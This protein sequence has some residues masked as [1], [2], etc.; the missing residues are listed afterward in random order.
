MI[1]GIIKAD[2]T[3]RLMRANLPATYEEFKAQ[4]AAGTLPLDVLF[5]EAGWSQLP[6]FLNK[7]NLLKDAT[8]NVFGLNANAVPNDVLVAIKSLIDAAVATADSKAKIAT[9]S[10]VGTNTGGASYPNSLTFDFVPVFVCMI[11]SDYNGVP[12]AWS[13]FSQAGLVVA[14]DGLTTSYKQGF[15]FFTNTGNYSYAKKSE[16]GKTIYWYNTETNSAAA[17]QLN[18][19]GRT[20]RWLAIG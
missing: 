16:D 7:A 11:A 9:G 20:Y 4:A 1:D 18:A 15:G 3:S 5:N 10:Y 19:S 14:I 17:Y 2:G 13:G 8:A 6:T 12:N